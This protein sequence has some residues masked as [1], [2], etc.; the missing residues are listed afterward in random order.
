[1]TKIEQDI[2]DIKE[3]ISI[4]RYYGT[5]DVH[6]DGVVEA[7]KRLI[8]IVDKWERR[9][10][11][12]IVIKIDDKLY[13]RIKYLEPRADTMLN[14]LM[15][16]VQNGTPL[17]DDAIIIDAKEQSDYVFVE[18]AKYNDLVEAA[19]KALTDRIKKSLHEGAT[20][21]SEAESEGKE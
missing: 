16:S 7:G 3:A 9:K 17:P 14:E 21:E 11:M 19:S 5:C 6:A 10:Q 2:K 15:R 4:I 12:Q 20:A 18:K 13:N 1:M 8:E